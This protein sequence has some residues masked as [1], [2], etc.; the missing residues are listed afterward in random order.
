MEFTVLETLEYHKI[1]E[2][3]A[4]KT[5]S[6]I[7]RE[8]AENLLPA[9]NIDEVKQRLDETEEAVSILTGYTNV[10]LGGIKDVRAIVK[11]A[12]LSAT[13][14]PHELAAVRSTLYA[15]RRLK[16]F[17]GDMNEYLPILSNYADKIFVLRNIEQI[18]DSTVT[19]HGRIRDDASIELKRIRNEI[20]TAQIRVKDKLESILRSAENQKLFQDSLVTVRGDRYVIPVKQEYR[21][22]FPGIVH[23][24]SASGATV[25]IE[26]M[27]IVN[28][29]NEIKQLMAAEYNEIDR[30]LRVVSGKISDEASRILSNCEMLAQIDFVFAKGRLAL[31]MKATKP[32]INKQGIVDIKQARHPLISPQDVVPIDIEI[33]KRFNTLLITGPNTGGKTVSLK[34]LGLFT[35]MTQAGMFIPAS[36]GAEMAIFDN[37]FVDIGDEQSIEHSLSTFS[38]HMTNL[39]SIL[40]KVTK[41]DLV[42]VDEIGSGTDPDEGAALAMAILNYLLE[43][44]V[45]TVATTH[46]SEL[47]SFAFSRHGIENAS[48][49]FDIQT[50]RPTYRLLIGIPGSSNAFAI[51]KRLGLSEKIIEGARKFIEKGH[52]EM[53]TMLVALE[54]QKRRYNELN[55]EVEITKRQIDTLKAELDQEKKYLDQKKDILLNKARHDAAAIVRNARREAEDI[56]RNLKSQFDEKD[57]HKRQNAI[58][59]ARSKLREQTSGLITDIDDTSNL[60]PINKENLAPGMSV[61]VTNLKQ[62]GIVLRVND[63]EVTVQM[64]ALK[65]SIPLSVCRMVEDSENKSKSTKTGFFDSRLPYVKNVARQIDLRG[66]TVE[67]AEKILEKFLDDAILAGLH[68]VIVIHG[69]GTGSLRK[70]VRL[71]LKNHQYVKE[72]SIAELNEGGD[73]ATVVR[74]V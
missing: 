57:A 43:V 63:N 2:M 25:F 30:I 18:I 49:E 32:N 56:I 4:A 6:S 12:K 69:K 70:G 35:L 52:A 9:N 39:V 61:Y 40:E 21:H 28:L 62:K 17:L 20:K 26:P 65:T 16:S 41:E 1:R 37:V 46:Y 72:I 71:Y 53:E 3:L 50:L 11:R 66:I 22:S 19:E 34:T 42:L 68:E 58:S 14:E 36:S 47:K 73:G 59:L 48:V 10:P 55:R 15:S 44:G 54:D 5:S 67:E 38:A 33:G 23:D 51:S 64:G 8:I 24:Q 31:A 45:K 13:L 60:P 27:P 74:L 7:G 29:N